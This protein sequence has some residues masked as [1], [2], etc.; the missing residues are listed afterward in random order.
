MFTSLIIFIVLVVIVFWWFTSNS[1]RDIALRHAQMYCQENNL[2]LLDEVVHCHRLRLCKDQ[3]R[4]KVKAIYCFYYAEQ[5]ID[6]HY[7]HMMLIGKELRWISSG[8]SAPIQQQTTSSSPSK[9]LD[10][11]H[12][13]DQKNKNHLH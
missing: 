7:C 13:K 1:R 9:V 8:S 3:G 10:F 2:Q 6:R 11:F 12:Y 4:L 5:D